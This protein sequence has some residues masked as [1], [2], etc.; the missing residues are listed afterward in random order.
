MNNQVS[1]FFRTY[2]LS[3]LDVGRQKKKIRRSKVKI[4]FRDMASLRPG[5]T[6]ES[7]S[8]EN[9]KEKNKNKK[10]VFDSCFPCQSVMEGPRPATLG[11]LPFC[12]I[13]WQRHGTGNRRKSS[14]LW[15]LHFLD[16]SV[17]SRTASISE[18]VS[19]RSTLLCWELGFQY[20][21]FH[22]HIQ[23]IELPG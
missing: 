12:V 18:H 9:Q 21:Y 14:A 20:S 4:I 10:L 19:S 23:F 3:T 11:R 5:G 22:G 2:N 8:Q 17:P 15:G 1:P 6:K 7:L 13:A 16:N